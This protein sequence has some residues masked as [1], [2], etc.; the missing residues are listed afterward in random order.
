MYN[1]R[2]LCICLFFINNLIGQEEV[3][4]VS[5]DV[6]IYGTLLEPKN[7]SDTVVLIISGSGETDRDGNT[8]KVGYINNCLKLL[9]ENLSTHNIASLRYDKR[10]VGKSINESITAKNLRFDHYIQ[11]AE[12]WIRYLKSKFKT[13]IIAGHSQGAF[14]GMAAI[15]EVNVD[16]FISIAGMAENTYTTIKKQLSAQPPFVLK[17][18]NPILDSLQK[19]IKVDSVPEY[20]H[21]IFHPDIQDYLISLLEFDPQNEIR[22][23]NVPILIVQGTTDIQIDL[24]AAKILAEQSENAELR[25]IEGMNHVLKE[26]KMDV[27]ENM[28]TYA[29]PQLELHKDLIPSIIHFVKN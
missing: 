4:I 10:G 1:F 13:V 22:K 28:A 24:K 27:N 9:A 8:P 5:N 7:T 14:V 19:G 25:I 18:A 17:D 20:L 11:D 23:L 6:T 15:Q 3:N 12:N 2:I 26:S 21:S 29:N 16:K